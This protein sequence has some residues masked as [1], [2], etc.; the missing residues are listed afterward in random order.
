METASHYTRPSNRTPKISRGSIWAFRSSQLPNGNQ[1]DA[2]TGKRH[3]TRFYLVSRQPL[4]DKHLHG[5][6]YFRLSA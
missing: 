3:R 5:D 1:G 2:E 6:N 4:S